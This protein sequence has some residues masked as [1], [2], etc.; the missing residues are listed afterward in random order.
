[1]SELMIGG[2]MEF[3]MSILNRQPFNHSFWYG[4]LYSSGRSALNSIL[5]AIKLRNINRILLPDYLCS[6]IVST[7]IA[8]GL[9]FEYYSLTDDLLPDIR[10]IEQKAEKDAILL[11]N[12][13]GMQDLTETIKGIK[14][15]AFECVVVEDDVQAFYSFIESNNLADYSFTSLRKWFAVPDGGIARSLN[16]DLGAPYGKNLFGEIKLSG[17]VLKGLRKQLGNIDETYL[18]LLKEGE[19]LIDSSISSPGLNITRDVMERTDVK[20]LA[21]VRKRNSEL[22]IAGLSNLG[23]SPIIQPSM[24]SIPF[25]IPLLLENRNRV[26]KKLFEQ[27][28]FCPVHWPL[29]G[30]DLE[31]G[32][33]MAEHELSLIIDHRYAVSDI[34]RI[35]GV[36]ST[37]I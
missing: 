12:Y 13:F 11:I 33:Y 19:D 18:K 14:E 20:R 22:M 31:R 28:I 29:D 15:I 7:V 1:M 36:L 35:L 30:L 16:N 4:V 21:L 17:L 10:S 37:A 26:R 34:N 8:A 23:I 24:T 2:E 9:E 5:E 6:S 27:E 32:R 25:F 3:D